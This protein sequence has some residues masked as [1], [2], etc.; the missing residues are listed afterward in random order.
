MEFY[1][2][3]FKKEGDLMEIYGK[4]FNPWGNNAPF[5][6]KYATAAMLYCCGT[7]KVLDTFDSYPRYLNY[8]FGI[9]DPIA[10]HKKLI[11]EGYYTK[12]STEAILETFRV[13][14][15]KEILVQNNLPSKGRRPALIEAILKNINPTKLNLGEF[16]AR[17]ELGES[18]LSKYSYVM[19]LRNYSIKPC[20]YA[21]YEDVHPGLTTDEII[22]G[23]LHNR[24]TESRLAE[25]YGIARNALYELSI[26]YEQKNAFEKALYKLI[27]V[28]YFDTSGYS[29]KYRDSL[30]RIILAPGIL[31]LICKYQEFYSSKMID[32][33]FLEY[34]LPEHYLTKNQFEKL[35]KKI[36]NN[37]SIEDID[38]KEL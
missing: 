27:C 20:E 19:T 25:D 18:Y 33:C 2:N 1:I 7:S 5:I 36:F 10:Y 15:L 17:S 21:E 4:P 11:S 23:I 3:S 8:T 24:Y 26:F 35:I 6:E 32:N 9:T 38:L 14:D 16:Y 34:A 31:D 13:A 37:N 29:N 30:E 28:L 22:L 12:A